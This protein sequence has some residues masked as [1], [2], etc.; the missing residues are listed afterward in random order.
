MNLSYNWLRTLVPDLN[1]TPQELAARLARYGA[2]VDELVPVGEPLRD[3]VI[4][5]TVSVRKHPNSDRLS[6]CEVDAGTGQLLSVVCGAPNV[7]ADRF[8]PFAPVGST[9]PGGIKLEQR[10]IRGELSQGMLCSP[11]ELALGRD[12]N[13]IM[14]LSGSYTPGQSFVQSLGLDDYRLL[15]DVTPNRPDLLSHW[16]VAREVAPRGNASLRS[17][18]RVDTAAN[19]WT[20]DTVAND[21]KIG[22]VTIRIDDVEGCP[23]YMAAVVRG[24]KVG[25]SP[26]WL[27]MRLRAIGQRPINNV[28]DA[29]N[30][31][32]H[33]LGQPMHAFDLSRLRG[34]QIVVRRARSGEK[35]VTLDG[36]ARE[37]QPGMLVIADAERATAIAGV[38]GGSESEVT[39][40]TTDVLIECAH[41]ER[42][43]VR[44]TRRALGMST[45]ASY[46]FERGVDPT[47][48]DVALLR[49]TELIVEIA[50]G[51]AERKLVDVVPAPMKARTLALRAARVRQVLGED[52]STDQINQL[53]EPIG[54]VTQKRDAESLELVV[55]GHR[56]FDVSEEIDLVEEVAR[57]HG[58]DNFP[59]ELRPFRPSTVPDH[60][61]SQ[62][63]DVLRTKLGGFGLLEARTAGFA[64]EADG[65]VSL[66]L[67]LSSAEGR[68]RRALLPG[69]LHR[70]EY[71]YTRGNRD[72]RLFEIGTSFEAAGVAA[73]LETIRLAVIITGSRTPPHWSGSIPDVDLWDI[74]GLADE[75]GGLLGIDIGIGGER[76]LPGVSALFEAGAAFDL[77]RDGKVVG[78]LGH[79]ASRNVDAPAWAAPIFGLEVVLEPQLRQHA[80]YR[81]LPQYPAIEQDL[82]L[83][84]PHGVSAAAVIATV[85]ASGGALLEDVSVFDLYEGKGIPEGTR[86]IAYRLRFRAPDRTLTDAD[87]ST[88][89][90]RILKRLKDEHGITRR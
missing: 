65:D 23:R 60:P 67:P 35:L 69:L 74:R 10:K 83:L 84:V 20:T 61:L 2:P 54:F 89:V 76:K 80:Q 3:V 40:G 43:Q 71:N 50:G 85:K 66:M 28:V 29:T 15:I 26:E 45:D 27:A 4:A 37:L 53:L 5:R 44:S 59:T 7:T 12:H 8:Y 33:E 63:E 6:L 90:G 81:T 70:A 56:W 75:L 30:F 79:I 22:G 16:G 34:H 64:S 9:L 52:F 88:A 42:K 17:P 77:L 48:M 38:M 31:V 78:Q 73:P 72:I 49:V 18:I 21:G 58:Y 13:G 68:L 86:S 55:P 62:L 82:A 41:F 1:D 14:E 57:R 11:S 25:P 24:V 51:D 47:R 19:G 39:E 87:A 32:L 36:V 46:R